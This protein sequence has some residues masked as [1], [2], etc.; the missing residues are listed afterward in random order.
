MLQVERKWTG[1]DQAGRLAA[2]L[3]CA[4]CHPSTW[5]GLSAGCGGMWNGTVGLSGNAASGDAA[6]SAEWQER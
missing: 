2:L 1:R 6:S 4:S 3:C 5:T